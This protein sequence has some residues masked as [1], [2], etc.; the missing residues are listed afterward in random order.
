VCESNSSTHDHFEPHER[1][2]I[3]II[4]FMVPNLFYFLSTYY[5]ACKDASPTAAG[6][7]VFGYAFTTAPVSVISSASVALSKRYRPQLWLGWVITLVGTALLTTIRENTSRSI[8]LGFQSVVGVGIGLTY[9]TTFFPV[10]APLPVTFNAHA[11]S[12]SMYFRGLA[13]IWGVTLGGTLLQNGLQSKL[14][15]SFTQLFDSSGGLAYAVIPQIPTLPQPLKDEV[16]SAFAQSLA[17]NWI[18]LTV[19]SGLGLLVSL[20]M[21]GLPLHTERDERWA[22][23]DSQEQKGDDIYVSNTHKESTEGASL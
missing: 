23:K 9:Y 14:P 4:A 11:L 8:S 21:K 10:L 1:Q 7:D 19:L 16:R 3:F 20:L 15:P 2:R 18:M 22:L 13:Q 12:L 5:Q 6:V 17:H